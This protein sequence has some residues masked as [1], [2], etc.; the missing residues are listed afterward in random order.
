MNSYR[1]YMNE[2]PEAKPILELATEASDYQEPDIDK[3][4][5]TAALLQ[6]GD[7]NLPDDNDDMNV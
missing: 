4:P 7:F 5:S 1:E 2:H 3:M 6:G